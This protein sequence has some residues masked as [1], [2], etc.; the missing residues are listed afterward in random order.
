M[1]G[2]DGSKSY[3]PTKCHSHC[4]APV[5]AFATAAHPNCNPTSCP[6]IPASVPHVRIVVTRRLGSVRNAV[7]STPSRIN[8]T[9]ACAENFSRSRGDSVQS[10]PHTAPNT[11]P[12][13][14]HNRTSQRGTP[15]Y[16]P[17]HHRPTHIRDRQRPRQFQRWTK[18]RRAQH[19]SPACS[20]RAAAPTN[21]PPIRGGDI[22]EPIPSRAANSIHPNPAAPNPNARI[23]TTHRRA[24]FQSQ[25]KS[26][27][28]PRRASACANCTGRCAPPELSHAIGLI[29][30]IFITSENKKR[31]PHITKP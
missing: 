16:H 2:R 22:I 25:Y 27:V 14:H 9:C 21:G 13:H 31:I 19:Q 4:A 1:E 11:V 29:K 7:S 3:A 8:V 24:A 5:L 6:K 15:K 10:N 30:T 28:C 12:P 23:R 18:R 26:H 17:A 20:K